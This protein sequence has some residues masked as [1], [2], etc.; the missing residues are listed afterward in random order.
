MLGLPDLEVGLVVGEVLEVVQEVLAQVDEVG[1][2]LGLGSLPSLP[3][4]VEVDVEGAD[5]D[6]ESHDPGLSVVALV[7]QVGLVLTVLDAEEVPSRGG[8]RELA[9]GLPERGVVGSLVV[10][11]VQ[12]HL[13]GMRRQLVRQQVE[14]SAAFGKGKWG[15]ERGLGLGKVGCAAD[16]CLYRDVAGDG[17]TV[18]CH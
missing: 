8:D 3:V 11:V 2:D 5:P 16:L 10:D 14:V 12:R 1:Q 6:G 9:L 17:G 15:R 7:V 13:E 4:D 18:A